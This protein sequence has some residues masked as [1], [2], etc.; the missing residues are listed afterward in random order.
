MNRLVV[1]ILSYD[2]WFYISH[3][4]LHSRILQKYHKL[5]HTRPNPNY[6]D[7]YI[8]DP[9]ETVFQGVGFLFP[10]IVYTYSVQDFALVLLFLNIRGMM[11]HDPRWVFL[12]GN[13]HLLHH[14]YGNCNY[15]Q[16]WI[17]SL[18]GTLHNRNEDYVYGLIYV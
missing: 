17:D 10:L 7:T 13:H 2:I 15:G 4:M 14:K 5:H 3:V 8:A 12:I 18:C 1:S 11:A 9:V 16:Y 6:E